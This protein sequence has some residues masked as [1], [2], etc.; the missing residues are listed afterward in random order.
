MARVSV[1]KYL[2]RRF[3]KVSAPKKSNHSHVI[4]IFGAINLPERLFKE[5][6]PM[7]FILSMVLTAALVSPIF[8]LAG[9]FPEQG[10][11]PV[12]VRFNDATAPRRR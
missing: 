5:A 4:N 2:F 12:R 8:L 3:Y 10:A 7:A 6:I 11:E 1:T 9:G